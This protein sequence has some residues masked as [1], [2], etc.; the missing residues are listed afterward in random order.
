MKYFAWDEA[1]NERLKAER[2][3]GFEE[4]VFHIERGD[5]LGVLDH[6]NRERYPGQRIYVV[7]CDEYVYLV[8]FV[9]AETGRFLETIIPSRV[10]TR[11]Y[12]AK[13]VAD[14]ET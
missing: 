11:R 9:E 7:R 5:V 14:D 3:I 2:G 10:A 1:K 13:E 4:I 12:L 8:P 6:P